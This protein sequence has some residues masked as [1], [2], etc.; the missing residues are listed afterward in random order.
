[1]QTKYPTL[2]RVFNILFGVNSIG[3]DCGFGSPLVTTR[4]EY[5]I[6]WINSIVYPKTK[7]LENEELNTE[8]LEQ[9]KLT[10]FLIR[11]GH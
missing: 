8:R 4:V 3:V 6:P 5:F 10:K 11:C 9:G 7:G 1:L 2:D